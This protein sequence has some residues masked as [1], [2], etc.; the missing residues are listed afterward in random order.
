MQGYSI[1]NWKLYVVG[2]SSGNNSRYMKRVY[3][4][5]KFK[6]LNYSFNKNSE[7]SLEV[8]EEIVVRYSVTSLGQI[9]VHWAIVS[10]FPEVPDS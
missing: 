4:Q 8:M 3:I 1:P 6:C 9:F 10:L 7:S 5:V 2:I